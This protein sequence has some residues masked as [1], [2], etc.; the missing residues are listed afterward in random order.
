MDQ[1]METDTEYRIVIDMKSNHLVKRNGDIKCYEST[2]EVI[3]KSL[4]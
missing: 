4:Q 2:N 1:N 3:I